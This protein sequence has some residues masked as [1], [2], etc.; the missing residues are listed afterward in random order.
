MWRGGHKT[1]TRNGGLTEK[2][3]RYVE[4]YG[5]R[6]DLKMWEDGK[7]MYVRTTWWDKSSRLWLPYLHILSTF[8]AD[9]QNKAVLASL[10]GR[11]KVLLSF[12]IIILYFDGDTNFQW[13]TVLL[14]LIF[15]L[16]SAIYSNHWISV[17]YFSYR[18]IAVDV[19]FNWPYDAILAFSLKLAV[20][21][22]RLISSNARLWTS[23]MLFSLI[24]SLLLN[25]IMWCT[26]TVRVH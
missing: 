11:N 9:T 13:R 25:I 24:I 1:Q 10:D 4:Q 19:F 23:D 8:N 17:H 6:L 15:V 26:L 14:F 2:D 16:L 7:E 21:V 3:L 20:L 5:T 18:S 12:T 22:G